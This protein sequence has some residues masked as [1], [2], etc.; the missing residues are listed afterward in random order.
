M[1][2]NSGQP[3]RTVA[4]KIVAILSA[5]TVGGALTASELARQTNL[6]VSTVHRLVRELA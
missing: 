2:G 1:A 6:P 3:G 4:S 5:F